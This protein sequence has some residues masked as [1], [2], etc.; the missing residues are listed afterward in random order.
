MFRGNLLRG[1]L[2]SVALFVMV[3]MLGCTAA[4][5]PTP[6]SA[7]KPTQAAKPAS[8]ATKPAAAATKAPAPAATKAAEPTKPA[9]SGP[10]QKISVGVTGS[11][12][13]AMF[14]VADRKYARE[15]GIQLDLIPF[16]AAGKMVPAQ[17]NG[18][19]DVAGGA[20]SVALYNAVGRGI[21]LR[22]VADRTG[23]A[24]GL[25]STYLAV[26][27]DLYDS[28]A[29]RDY[30]DLKGKKIAIA[31][32]GSA[33]QLNAV[34]ALAKGGYKPTDADL[35]TMGFPDMVIALAGKS[36]DAAIMT[37]PSITQGE[38][39]GIL[40]PLKGND[41]YWP[42]QQSSVVVYSPQFAKN[43]D[44]A[45]KFMVAYVQAV[46]DYYRA[47][48]DGGSKKEYTDI[49]V[50]TTAIKDRSVWERAR[51]VGI[52]PDGYVN[53]DSLIRDYKWYRENA[54][55]KAEIDFKEIVDNSFLDFA[56]QKLGKYKK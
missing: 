52:N 17:A 13:D 12:G 19:L 5:T 22:I 3:A 27:K 23:G 30:K 41:D 11:N 46:R 26:R 14:H 31:S 48:L 20:P 56:N 8:E 54:D 51:P 44:V 39:K 50:E 4:P 25:S 32:V 10:L 7:P 55:L 29:I 37:E 49:L 15:L 35:I 45:N 40:V 18:E 33:T 21:P 1:A 16:D 2:L 28:G 34:M 9:A 36:I 47:Y 43:K 38:D 24:P 42:I 6:T 53:V